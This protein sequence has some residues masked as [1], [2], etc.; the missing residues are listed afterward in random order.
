M[1]ATRLSGEPG[2]LGE[3]I[4]IALKRY[5]SVPVEFLSRLTGR[6]SSTIER[7]LTTLEQKKVVKREDQNVK[8]DVQEDQNA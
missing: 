1:L 2:N 3:E 8:L 4:V 6:D 5:G 7:Y